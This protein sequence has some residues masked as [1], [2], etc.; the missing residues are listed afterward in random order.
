MPGIY[1]KK[2]LLITTDQELLSRLTEKV[3][4]SDYELYTVRDI[5]VATETLS[6]THPNLVIIDMLVGGVD[7]L[8]FLDALRANTD[9]I[10][11]KTPVIIASQ[12]GDIVEI[13]RALR[14]GVTDY[15]VKSNLDTEQV[16]G[17]I[18]K[19]FG[20]FSQSPLEQTVQS[21]APL[22]A[23]SPVG[24][25][26]VVGLSQTRLLIVEDD[27]FLR[28]LATQKLT[29][30]HFLVSAAVDGEQGIAIAEKEIPD[31]VL[32]DILLPGID[33]FEVLKRIRA[34]PTLS[35][36]RI[37]MLSNFGQREDIERA[38]K[39][40]AEQFLIKAN[41]T[42]DEIVDEVKKIAAKA[43]G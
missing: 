21:S 13:G 43:K 4:T 42:L 38:L 23:A 25:P 35:N 16:M 34:N 39:G 20:G 30:E 24:A 26:P 12:T 22:S 28:D 11:A 37:A 40:G 19:L 3:S 7:G 18:K 32:L 1:A 5:T 15:F 27:K 2:I 14:L 10:I 6:R 36:T 31:I 8:V 33:G 9:P 17:K 41:Y 29:K